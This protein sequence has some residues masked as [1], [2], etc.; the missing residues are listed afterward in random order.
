MSTR[1][2]CLTPSRWMSQHDAS[3]MTVI[4]YEQEP[5]DMEQIDDLRWANPPV[6]D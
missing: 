6:S 2:C 3:T 1:S 5:I 4:E